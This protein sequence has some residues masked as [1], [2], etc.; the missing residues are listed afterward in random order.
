MVMYS[1]VRYLTQSFSF[2][3]MMFRGVSFLAFL[4]MEKN[5]EVWRGR[6]RC[7]GYFLSQDVFSVELRMEQIRAEGGIG[8]G[9]QEGGDVASQSFV[10]HRVQSKPT[11]DVRSM[12]D[13]FL[14]LGKS[15]LVQP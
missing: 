13:H 12:D 5:S 11:I 3:L 1:S 2:I 8:G 4:I 15:I 7:T 10:L 9:L 6:V 14:R